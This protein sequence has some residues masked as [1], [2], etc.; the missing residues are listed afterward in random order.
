M[1]AFTAAHKSLPLP[2]FARVT[3]LANGRSVVVR[4]NDRG[5]FHEG[6]VV[7]LSWAAAV[8]PDMHRQ[9]PAQVEVRALSPG[10]PARH[11]YEAVAARGAAEPAAVAEAPAPSAID[12]LVDALPIASAAAGERPAPPVQPAT[13]PARQTPAATPAPVP[14][15]AEGV[16]PRYAHERRFNMMQNGRVMTADDFDAWLEERQIDLRGLQAV[17]KASATPEPAGPQP[18]TAA[19]AANVPS[20]GHQQQ[21]QAAGGV[22]LQV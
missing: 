9:G 14:E 11:T 18:A 13:Q 10:E 7:D 15:I 17:A 2:S 1:Y 16:D 20:A 5:P 21:P 4:V 19:A 3:N 8:K 6:R 12:A 22:T